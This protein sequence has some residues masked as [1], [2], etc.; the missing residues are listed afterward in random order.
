MRRYVAFA[1][2]ALAAVALLAG[3]GSKSSTSSST[4]SG[5]SSKSAGSSSY[6]SSKTTT[7]STSSMSSAAMVKAA[8]V[9]PGTVLVGPNG[10]TL[11]L[12]E[13]DHGTTSACS[14]ACAQAWPPLTT[15][16]TPKAS[17][18]VK[19]SLLGTTKRSDGTMQ[20][21]YAGHPLYYFQ[22]DS[23]A[24]QSNGQGSK[25]F[26]AGWYVVTPAGKKIDES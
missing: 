18:A 2:V 21:T 23:A 3:C 10:R 7:S 1:V 25:A 13:K 5:A 26:G 6:G 24:G 14:G 8:K 20:V 15:S 16:G 22:G 17:G 4:T 11:Y 19:A 12:F 9:E